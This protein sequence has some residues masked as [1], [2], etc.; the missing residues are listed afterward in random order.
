MEVS[1]IESNHSLG[2][3]NG[4]QH[5]QHTVYKHSHL[6]LVITIAFTRKR[7]KA[8][9]SGI[10]EMCAAAP[11]FEIA[12]KDFEDEMSFSYPHEPWS[13]VAFMLNAAPIGI[14]TSF[15]PPDTTDGETP[16]IDYDTSLS[17]ESLVPQFVLKAAFLNLH[18]EEA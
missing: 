5:V 3:S 15:E 11:S 4:P 18:R 17:R 10:S 13:H 7:E 14:T 1:G 2:T 8:K 16:D 12:S 6:Y 9:R